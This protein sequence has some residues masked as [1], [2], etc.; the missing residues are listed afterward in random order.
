MKRSEALSEIYH[1]GY[2]GDKGKAGLIA[3][4]KRIGYTAAMK[5]YIKGE[6]TKSRGDSCD[7]PKCKKGE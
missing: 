3:A 4:Q 1:C 5:E 6:K 2:V 7:C